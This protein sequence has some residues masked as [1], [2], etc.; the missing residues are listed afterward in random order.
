MEART[1]ELKH[2]LGI[3]V[4]TPLL[5]ASFSSKG[6]KFQ[7]P[8]SYAK[9]KKIKSEVSDLIKNT[10][11]GITESALVSAF[12]MHYYIG[13]KE[14]DLRKLKLSPDILFIDS[15]GYE[16]I[17]DYDLT[18]IYKYPI[19]SQSWDEKLHDGILSNIQ[20]IP[21]I[22][23]SYDN[24]QDHRLSLEKQIA[25][26][27]KMFDRF[28]NQMSDFLIKPSNKKDHFININEVIENISLLKKFNIIGF[29]EKELG[30]S[31]NERMKNIKL[32][33]Q[34]LDQVGCSSPLHIFG[35]L[36]PMTSVLYFISGAEIFDGLTWLR[37]AFH[38]GMTL[39]KSNA[40][41]LEN[42]YNEKDY[43]NEKMVMMQNLITMRNLTEEMRA[44]AKNYKQ[45]K[46][47][48][49]FKCFSLIGETVKQI[50]N[51]AK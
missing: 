17:E 36:D 46:H 40:D 15:G 25:R 4:E 32:V 41:I 13:Q 51:T 44:F 14:N 2:P 23:V 6:F 49:A 8:K 50:I 31:V 37:F 28:P 35:N 27:K 16:T 18:D 42:R 26:A 21:C 11:E 24:G 7:Q 22:Y 38:K 30:A 45:G 10:A 19:V 1:S 5:V 12:D 3:T 33:R 47:D 20:T 29:T 43:L 48:D 34:A 9:V 39:Y